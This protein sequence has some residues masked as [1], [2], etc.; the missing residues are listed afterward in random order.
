[1]EQL[2]RSAESVSLARPVV[3]LVGDPIALPLGERMHGG[4]FGQILPDES[5]GVLVGAA[6]PGVMRGGEE[7]PQW[8]GSFD[9]PVAVELAA[10]VG[11]D[12]LVA[13]RVAPDQKFHGLPDL[14]LCPCRE[15]GDLNEAG[16]AI[17]EGEDAGF[18]TPQ[19]RVYLPMAGAAPVLRPGRSIRDRALAGKPSPAVVMPVAFPALLDSL[20]KVRVEASSMA[21][22]IPDVLVDRLVADGQLPE[23]PE[24]TGDLFRT[25]FAREQAP[26]EPPFLHAVAGA[27]SRTTP[28]AAGHATGMQ[29]LV[30]AVGRI[31]VAADFTGYRARA[32]PELPGNGPQAGFPSP[33]GRDLVAFVVA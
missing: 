5:V 23:P 10:V 8:E 2:R 1:M 26:D 14:L 15:L 4:S 3:Q 20:A 9:I 17:H 29:G 28:P 25:E 12:R 27:L 16:F 13:D 21:A 24:E 7:E 19:N 32:S 31:G 11:R 18:S 33:H 30:A 22:V 6:R